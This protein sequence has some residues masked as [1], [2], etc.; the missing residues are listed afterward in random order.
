MNRLLA[1]VA[2][3]SFVSVACASADGT[4]SPTTSNPTT[5]PDQTT[6][7]TADPNA[8]LDPVDDPVPA[9]LPQLSAHNKATGT[10]VIPDLSC[11]AKALPVSTGTAANREFHLIELGGA[12]TDRVGDAK[13]D[14]F[15]GN[16]VNKMPD[17]TVMV[18]KGE[19]MSSTGV[20]NA[21]VPAGWLAYKVAPSMGYVPIVGLDLEVPESGPVLPAVPTQAKVDALSVLIGGA[22]YEPTK[23]AGRAVVRIKD[24][25]LNALTNAHVVIEIDGKV[26]RPSKGEGL[27]RSYFGDSEFPGPG[28]WTSRS[29]VVAFIEIPAGAK[30][31][32]IV[33]RGN[34]GGE[35]KVIGLRKIPLVADGL[36]AAKVMPFATP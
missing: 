24:C 12:D 33:A 22:T 5:T 21:S 7:P 28:T 23:G 8:A 11:F 31:L 15:V 30:Q 32:R 27:R 3:L 2:S 13:V 16:E 19:D 26:R 4:K 34:V 36:V 17:A 18:K 29:G 25:A 9:G 1:L 35:T 20:F 10:D 14:V 6:N